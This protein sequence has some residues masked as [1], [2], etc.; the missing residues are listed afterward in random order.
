[1]RVFTTVPQRNL[2]FVAL[3]ARLASIVSLSHV[4]VEVQ[5]CAGAR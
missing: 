4:T 1:M 3:A 2:R 5:V